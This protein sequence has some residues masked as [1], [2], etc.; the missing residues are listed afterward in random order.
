MTHL[1]FQD[2]SHQLRDRSLLAKSAIDLT[3][4]EIRQWEKLND[5]ERNEE[6]VRCL[7]HSIHS[8]KHILCIQLH[9]ITLQKKDLAL[10]S[11]NK[12]K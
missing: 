3:L 1:F 2:V 8:C 4:E 12:G 9:F 5:M 7:Q 10:M 11:Q 6:L